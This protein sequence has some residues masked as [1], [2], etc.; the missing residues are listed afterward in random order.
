MS[1]DWLISD[2][3]NRPFAVRLLSCGVPQGSVLGPFMFLTVLRRKAAV[4]VVEVDV[5]L[6]WLQIMIQIMMRKTFTMNLCHCCLQ[7]GWWILLR[8]VLCSLKSFVVSICR[9]NE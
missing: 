4:Q 7:T 8:S 2:P 9:V 5:D 3:S 6:L 1:L